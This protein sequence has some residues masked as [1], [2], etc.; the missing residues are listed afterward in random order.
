[1]KRLLLAV[2][3]LPMIGTMMNTP[4]H[5]QMQTSPAS[6]KKSVVFAC[7]MKAMTPAQSEAAF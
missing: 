7:D 5:G 6:A 1:M 3:T 4:L 2:V